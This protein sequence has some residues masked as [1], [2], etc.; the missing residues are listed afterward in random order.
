MNGGCSRVTLKGRV[1][2]ED[3]PYVHF[4]LKIPL[5]LPRCKRLS[6]TRGVLCREA[7]LPY[8]MTSHSSG[9]PCFFPLTHSLPWFTMAYHGC[10]C[11]G[12]GKLCLSFYKRGK[13]GLKKFKVC[14]LVLLAVPQLEQGL[15]V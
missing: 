12:H 2:R 7:L 4:L 1:H 15:F 10:D 8:L 9:F 5:H 6:G 3:C 13:E 14:S 11:K